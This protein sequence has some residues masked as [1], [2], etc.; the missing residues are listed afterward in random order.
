[1]NSSLPMLFRDFATA[2]AARPAPHGLGLAAAP[3]EGAERFAA[4]FRDLDSYTQYWEFYR[5]ELNGSYMNLIVGV[6]FP[7]PVDAWETFA[8]VESTAEAPQALAALKESIAAPAHADALDQID[9][10]LRDLLNEHFPGQGQE[11]FDVDGYLAAVGA[12]ARD[13]LPV[14]EN[15]LAR[16]GGGGDDVSH[17]RMDDPSMWF[18][19]SAAVDCPSMALNP[20]VV[21][22]MHGLYL[23][24]AVFGSAMD[25]VFRARG[26]TRPEYHGDAATEK[27]LREQARQWARDGN[28]A[29]AQVRDLYRV[30]VG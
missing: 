21:A 29:R 3:T 9:A 16:V 30:F 15:R 22:P 17:H 8:R 25:C 4:Y 1:M 7:G 27:L 24:G 13:R 10:L 28:L 2:S 11:A 12:F 20:A 19:W 26:R 14:D 5:P 23:P 18:K 6:L